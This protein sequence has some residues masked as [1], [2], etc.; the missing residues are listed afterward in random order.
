MHASSLPDAAPLGARRSARALVAVLAGA[1]IAWGALS[2]VTLTIGVLTEGYGA[3]LDRAALLA[4][5]ELGAMAAATMSAGPLLGRVRE[6]VLALAGALLAGGVNA[7]TAL[8]DASATLII[9]RVLAGVGLGWMAAALNT[10]ISR[11]PA[12]GRLF[13][14]ANFGCIALAALFFAAL[15]E[16]YARLGPRSYFLAYGVLC[17]LAGVALRALPSPAAGRPSATMPESARA[18]TRAPLVLFLAV[19]LIWLSYAAV[20]SLTERFGRHLGLDDQTVGHALG[21]GTLTGLAG[22]AA[23]TALAGRLR[24]RNA[25]IATSLASGLCYVWMSYCTSGSSY[26]VMLCVWGAV[27]CPILAY[28]YAVAAHVDR[29]GALG[30]HIG[31]GTAIA[32]AL[33]PLL[34]AWL[35]QTLGYRGLTLVAC[36]ATALACASIACLGNSDAA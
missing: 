13:V 14:Q 32:T 22:A 21:L 29:T 20:W 15:P 36:L 31:G 34:G 27:F 5:L 4:T 33:G 25:L 17:A 8:A 24:P 26:T 9:L 12:P 19:S 10:A 16:I 30:R 35:E 6:P 23:A 3:S 7:L 2:Y 18:A 1:G 28:A 11:A